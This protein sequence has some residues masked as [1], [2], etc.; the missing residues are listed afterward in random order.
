MTGDSPEGT[1]GGGAYITATD[2]DELDSHD[3]VRRLCDLGLWFVL[4]LCIAWA[5]QEDRRVRVF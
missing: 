3:R 4:D 2:A 1:R 5:V